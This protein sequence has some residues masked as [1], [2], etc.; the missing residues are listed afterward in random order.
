MSGS[1]NYWRQG[2]DESLG[3]IR[4]QR[5]VALIVQNAE[6]HL[7]LVTAA[8]SNPNPLYDHARGASHDNINEVRTGDILYTMAGLSARIGAMTGG[9]GGERHNSNKVRA[10]SALNGQGQK[11][12]HD[13]LMQ[14][15]QFQGIAEQGTH[16]Q[17]N[18]STMFNTIKGGILTMFNTYKVAIEE[19]DPL[20][21]WAPL[22]E[23]LPD[24]KGKY[25]SQAD[26][27]GEVK[28][29]L[30][31]FKPERHRA[32]PKSIYNCL[33]GPESDYTRAFRDTCQAYLESVVEQATI[34]IRVY[35]G[36]AEAMNFYRDMRPSR[37]GTPP[38][39]MQS[40]LINALFK[41]YSAH[42]PPASLM[43]G[44]LSPVQEL[45]RLEY[46]AAGKYCASVGELVHNV[47][48]NVVGRATSSALP[49]HAVNVQI[50]SYS[51][52]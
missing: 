5:D 39:A 28:L 3:G 25:K 15:L 26:L 50:C 17:G 4:R 38:T 37:P 49:G 42:G 44:A 22:P 18:G 23:E 11:G 32:T 7:G 33:V 12:Q 40:R 30:R 2:T 6:L 43:G 29:V 52:K 10:V 16:E 51:A 24:L 19:G 8:K 27:N 45:D 46:E 36:E 9:G 47:N 20:E 14:R 21:I 31:P 41:R 1:S 34:A 48:K 13:A 35:Q